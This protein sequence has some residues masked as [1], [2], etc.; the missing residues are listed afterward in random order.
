MNILSVHVYGCLSDA[1]FHLDLLANCLGS[2][3]LERIVEEGNIATD[4]SQL[5]PAI[6]SHVCPNSWDKSSKD[7]LKPT[8]FTLLASILKETKFLLSHLE[9]DPK[10]VGIEEVGLDY[11]TSC[12][13]KHHHNE[14]HEKYYT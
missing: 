9:W 5:H 6:A 13:C 12:R 1:H 2:K 4:L 10:C 8:S 7:S 14:R 3:G 11:T